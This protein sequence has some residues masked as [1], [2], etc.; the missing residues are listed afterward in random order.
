MLTKQEQIELGMIMKNY[1]D[2]VTDNK[3]EAIAAHNKLVES[4]IPMAY[5]IA[6]KTI[7]IANAKHYTYE[8]AAQDALLTLNEKMWEYDPTMNTKAGTFIYFWLRKAASSG[9]NNAYSIKLGNGPKDRMYRVNK[10]AEEWDKIKNPNMSKEEYIYK[11]TK[12]TPSQINQINNAL[13]PALSLDEKISSENFLLSETIED[14]SANI[15]FDTLN[16]KTLI[17]SLSFLTQ[18]ERVIL[19]ADLDIEY[20]Y[21][22]YIKKMEVVDFNR[23]ARKVYHKIKKAFAK[24]R[25]DI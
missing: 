18:E 5:D 6:G 13:T 9:I 10:A 25:G 12:T 3:E 11:E 14:E 15:A 4:Y 7:K 17:D 20:D 24:N 23:A 1:K 16:Y 2:G 22:D 21:P 19:Y 8:D